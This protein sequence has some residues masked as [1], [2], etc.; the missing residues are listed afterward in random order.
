MIQRASTHSEAAE[1]NKHGRLMPVLPPCIRHCPASMALP[2]AQP[3]QRPSPASWSQALLTM[4][5]FMSGPRQ[6]VCCCASASCCGLLTSS[7]MCGV[8]R[9]AQHGRGCVHKGLDTTAAV[10][11]T[12]AKVLHAD[13]RSRP[14]L[15]HARQQ[16]TDTATA[17]PACIS[18]ERAA[19]ATALMASG[20]KASA[21]RSI[22]I[23]G[24]LQA[25]HRQ[26]QCKLHA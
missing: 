11:H 22:S 7:A 23:R 4:K 14:A 6:R 25:E 12:C 20:L 3:H 18:P 8:A 2:A 13:S 9:T 26:R 19:S 21:F 17:S 24:M 16:Q 1:G 10:H 5:A 15:S